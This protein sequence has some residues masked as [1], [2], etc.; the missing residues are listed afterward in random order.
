MDGV[1]HYCCLPPSLSFSTAFRFLPIL[2]VNIQTRY[3]LLQ[4][5]YAISCAIQ[6]LISLSYGCLIENSLGSLCLSLVCPHIELDSW[7]LI[8]TFHTFVLSH[9]FVLPVISFALQLFNAM[10]ESKIYFFAHLLLLRLLYSEVTYWF[11]F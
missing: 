2:F 10:V 5:P 1:Y 6:F 9:K 3:G 8:C 4:L 11:G 7:L